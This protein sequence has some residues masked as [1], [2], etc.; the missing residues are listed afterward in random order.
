MEKTNGPFSQY[1]IQVPQFPWYRIPEDGIDG[2][3]GIM[4][5]MIGEA[6]WNN[7]K[8]KEKGESLTDGQSITYLLGGGNIDPAKDVGDMTNADAEKLFKDEDPITVVYNEEDDVWSGIQWGTPTLLVFSD[9]GIKSRVTGYD[10]TAQLNTDWYNIWE[11]KLMEYL[12]I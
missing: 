6:V 12:A 1:L 3:N 11:D 5:Q 2:A 10:E 8:E 7:S 4:N 9:G